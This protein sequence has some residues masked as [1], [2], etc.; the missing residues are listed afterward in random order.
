V[1][2]AFITAYAAIKLDW[3]PPAGAP[4]AASGSGGS[5]SPDLKPLARKL[6]AVLRMTATYDP[7]GGTLQQAMAS[8]REKM[9]AA[10]RQRPSTIQLLFCF[11]RRVKEVLAGGSRRRELQPT[12]RRQTWLL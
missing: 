5:A 8:V 9:A 4:G 2:G 6:M 3:I 10:S 1:I 12:L 7:A 11:M